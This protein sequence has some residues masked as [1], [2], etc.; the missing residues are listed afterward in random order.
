MSEFSADGTANRTYSSDAWSVAISYA[1]D[2]SGNQVTISV[3][4][5]E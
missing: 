2:E 1:E 3:Y 4:A 5:A